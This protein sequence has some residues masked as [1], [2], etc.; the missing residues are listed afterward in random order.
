MVN[1]TIF[2]RFSNEQYSRAEDT[3]ICLDLLE[4]IAQENKT[5]L[6][7]IYSQRIY[8]MGNVNLSMHTEKNPLHFVEHVFVKKDYSLRVEGEPE[9]YSMHRKALSQS[10]DG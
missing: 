9:E 6:S 10:M 7:H 3:T 5:D 4:E 8:P 1:K 2:K